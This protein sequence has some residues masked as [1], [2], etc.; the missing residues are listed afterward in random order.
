MQ[1]IGNSIHFLNT[2][3]SAM[4]NNSLGITNG[5]QKKYHLNITII[6]NGTS[7]HE[8]WVTER[9]ERERRKVRSH[10]GHNE[11]VGRNSK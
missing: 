9:K 4:G 5:L 8:K 11:K 10:V 6:T 7:H 2:Q 1:C 3:N